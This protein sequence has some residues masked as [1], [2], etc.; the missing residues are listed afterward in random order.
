MRGDR[1]PSVDCAGASGDGALEGGCRGILGGRISRVLESVS[2]GPTRELSCEVEALRG[3]AEAARTWLPQTGGC[4]YLDGVLCAAVVHLLVLPQ[5]P[6][7]LDHP[8]GWIEALLVEADSF[9][10]GALATVGAA[11]SLCRARGRSVPVPERAHA[12]LAAAG[13]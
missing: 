4:D 10:R 13:L 1:S 9:R 2:E 5:V 8:A 6:L 3:V 11:L 7:L 12:L